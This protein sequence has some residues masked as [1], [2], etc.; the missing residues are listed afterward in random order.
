MGFGFRIFYT[1]Y[2][3]TPT[4]WKPMAVFT[5]C[6]IFCG[7]VPGFLAGWVYGVKSTL[8]IQ[9]DFLKNPPSRY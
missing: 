6:M 9:K 7:I 3:E 4:D 5:I 8:R 1:A 2:N